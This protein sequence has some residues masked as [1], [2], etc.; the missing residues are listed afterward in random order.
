MEKIIIQPKNVRCF[1]NI[2]S[3][4]DTNNFLG[5]KIVKGTATVDGQSSTVYT[6]SY[7]A[8]AYLTVTGANY[9]G[10]ED[11]LTLN[12]TLR[13]SQDTL[14]VNSAVY[15]ECDGIVYSGRTNN[16]GRCTFE[17][18]ELTAGIH[19]IKLFYAGSSNNGG[20]F[21]YHTVLVGDDPLSLSLYGS[22]NLI[23]TGDSMGLF[24]GLSPGVV[25]SKV[26]FYEVYEP[27]VTVTASPNPIQTGE[28]TDITATLK[29]SDGSRIPDK[30]VYFYEKQME[31]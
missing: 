10:S 30:D 11:T 18:E 21:K 17:L 6:G 3:P 19:R 28:D 13:N 5:G 23:Q 24:A 26:H 27:T 31:D 8:N 20:C 12:C 1:G 22:A 25:G 14:L 4:K 16:Y 7:I 15:C 2:V 29:D 9:I